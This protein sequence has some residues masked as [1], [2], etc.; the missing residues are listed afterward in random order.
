MRLISRKKHRVLL[1]QCG[2][3]ESLAD[4]Y[5]ISRK[6]IEEIYPH[7]IMSEDEKEVRRIVNKEAKA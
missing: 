5:P 1:R 4:V 2:L 6:R 3:P 7:L